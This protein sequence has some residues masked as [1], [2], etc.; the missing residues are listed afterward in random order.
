MQ[1][2]CPLPAIDDVDACLDL[3][4]RLQLAMAGQ[5]WEQFSALV[6]SNSMLNSLVWAPPLRTLAKADYTDLPRSLATAV[7]RLRSGRIIWQFIGWLG[8]AYRGMSISAGL[9]VRLKLR[10]M[11]LV[12]VE[13][14]LQRGKS[15]CPV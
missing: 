6:F 5:R 14:L 13:C 3:P 2:Y 12:Y 15:F 9:A 1:E 10:L 8:R 11:L 7:A 4:R